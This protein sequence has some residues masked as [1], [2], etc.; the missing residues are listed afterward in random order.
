MDEDKIYKIEKVIAGEK[1]KYPYM[2]DY[3][4]P[5]KDGYLFDG[6]KFNGVEYNP[7]FNDE[8]SNPFGPI[9]ESVDITPIWDKLNIYAETNHTLVSGDGDSDD[10]LTKFSYWLQSD[11]GKK[12]TD[13]VILEDVALN[14][15]ELPINFDANSNVSIVDNKNVKTVKILEND[16]NKPRFY[17]FK[18]KYNK[19]G[20]ETDT[21]EV[22]QVG[23][24]QVILPPFDYLTF[25][26]SWDSDAGRDL[27][28]ATF[29]RNSNIPIESVAGKTLNDFYV[30]YSGS[31]NKE[32]EQYLIHGGDNTQ[33]GAEGA[34][35]NWKKI[36]DRDLISEGI[37]TLYLDVYANWYA[38][39]GNGN[40]SVS[41]K[42]Y[43]GN[44]GL[45]KDGFVFK[46]VGDT[47]QISDK[48]LN[49]LNAYAFSSAN[50]SNVKSFYSKVA[51]VEYDVRSKSAV[52]IGEYTRSGREV[53]TTLNYNSNP[54]EYIH[55]GIID[56]DSLHID[57]ASHNGS[58][59]L[60]DF[61]E[62]IDRGNVNRYGFKN[63]VK[64][65]DPYGSASLITNVD[66]SVSISWSIEANMTGE[67]RI[68]NIKIDTDN[69][70][71]YKSGHTITLSIH[72]SK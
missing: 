48:T 3:V 2:T 1:A 72:Q 14:I 30:G 66:G 11:K 55:S 23:K 15:D 47:V 57:N 27:D 64:V 69:T 7:P 46:P 29:V 71:A 41:F 40:M 62:C 35:V 19:G 60:S 24:E 26:Y 22:K 33:S 13:G 31:H 53:I 50:T 8:N 56:I 34:M 28:S 38:L 39:K 32:V 4:E 44:D 42:T 36:C 51:T 9:T 52:L 16:V 21:I 65:S 12:I 70:E 37:N 67:A 63:E 5:G 61:T 54:V 17:R 59:T 25:T 58:F 10:D 49:G 6:W 20:M 45:E 43:K 68:L 18:A